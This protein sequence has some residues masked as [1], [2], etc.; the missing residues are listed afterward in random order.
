MVI[1]AP[2]EVKIFYA[3]EMQIDPV[4]DRNDELIPLYF[5]HW[6]LQLDLVFE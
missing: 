1:T 5:F 6:E 2:T 3:M 4:S